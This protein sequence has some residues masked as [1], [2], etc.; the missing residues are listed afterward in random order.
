MKRILLFLLILSSPILLTAQAL[1]ADIKINGT[2]YS[3]IDLCM[4]DEMII[5]GNP[6]GGVS[7]YVTHLWTGGG[8]QLSPTNTPSTFF[9]AS[10]LDRSPL[11]IR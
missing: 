4:N 6:S 10:F 8:S 5:A 2:S 1:T 9:T 7:P 3:S 11:C